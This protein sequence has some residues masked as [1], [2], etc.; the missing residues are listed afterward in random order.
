MQQAA[1]QLQTVGGASVIS[2]LPADPGILV[3]GRQLRCSACKDVTDA[4]R[5]Y[6]AV[7]SQMSQ[8]L[9]NTPAGRFR[10]PSQ[11]FLR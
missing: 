5:Y 7:V 10:L 11:L 6:N 4:E 8:H 1:E 9:G 3:K 2:I